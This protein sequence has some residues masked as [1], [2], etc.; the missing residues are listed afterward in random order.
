MSLI[1]QLVSAISDYEPR[2]ITEDLPE[3]G[4]LVPVTRHPS[5]PEIILTR[6]SQHLNTHQGQVAFPGGKYD[7]EDQTVLNTALRESHEEI[8]L[9]PSQVEIIGPLSQVISLHGIRV[10]P[11]VGLVDNDIELT[12][13]LEELDSIFQVPANYLATAEPKR[14]DRMT[15]KGMAL[16]VPSYDYDYQGEMYEIWGLSAI[17]LVE[18][19]NVAFDADITIFD[20][21]EAQRLKQDKE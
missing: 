18:L 17:V 15:Y 12:P 9:H 11:Y 3:A 13:N 2:R 4:I 1:E 20:E 10:T 8:G 5:N 6:R 7:E 16:S 19:L 21:Y 14:R